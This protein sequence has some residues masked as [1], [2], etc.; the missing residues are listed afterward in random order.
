MY[1]EDGPQD[2]IQYTAPAC[3]TATRTVVLYGMYYTIHHTIVTHMRQAAEM[4]ATARNSVRPPP[5]CHEAD[6]GARK[7]A[8]IWKDSLSG[9]VS[10]RSDRNHAPP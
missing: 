1:G 3:S 7:G 9:R 2:R 4:C 5:V 8:R 10:F 6:P